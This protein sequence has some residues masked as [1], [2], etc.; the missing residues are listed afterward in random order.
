M[1]NLHRERHDLPK[2]RIETDDDQGV[3]SQRNERTN[4]E[5]EVA[6]ADED[7]EGYDEEGDDDRPYSSRL[8]IIS[9]SRTYL[10][11]RHDTYVFIN[12]RRE[13]LLCRNVLRD[14]T[15]ILRCYIEAVLDNRIKVFGL[16]LN[17]DIGR[18]THLVVR[19]NRDHVQAEC[20]T[21]ELSLEGIVYSNTYVIGLNRLLVANNKVATTGEVNTAVQARSKQTDEANNEHHC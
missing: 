9:D 6:E 19:A 10:L 20:L 17:T 1:V 5:C 15:G 12:L 13:E 8:D 18:D 3:V 11:R 4:R 14:Q 2:E 21:R 16:V 7:V